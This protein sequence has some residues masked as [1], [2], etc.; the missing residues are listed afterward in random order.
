MRTPL[1][2][3]KLKGVMF[4]L[5]QWILKNTV[6]SNDE[7]NIE[8]PKN[9]IVQGQ[10]TTEDTII[11]KTLTVSDKSQLQDVDVN[12]NLNITGVATV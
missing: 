3:S 7:G 11:N 4:E 10:L 1:Y 2:F 8:I 9:A 12:G 6:H 5:V